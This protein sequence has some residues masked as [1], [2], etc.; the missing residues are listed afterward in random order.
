MIERRVFSGEVRKASDATSIIE[1]YGAMFNVRS[2]DMGF[3]EV[4]E[5]GSF[6]TA[7]MSDVRMLND[8]LSHMILARTKSGTLTVG[9]DDTG[10]F[11]RGDVADTSFGRDLLVSV[12]RGDVDQS[13]FG[14]SVEKDDWEYADGLLLRHIVKVSSVV[15]VSPTA[16]PAYP[17]T[18]IDKRKLDEI[19]NILSKPHR[20]IE[21]LDAMVKVHRI[22]YS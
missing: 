12:G 11:Y 21:Y 22:I 14:F 13:S 15:D 17:Q 2:V 1:G 3:T 4:I 5:K 8:H 7:D 9:I 16:F 18:H 20:G 10:L 6:D 19:R